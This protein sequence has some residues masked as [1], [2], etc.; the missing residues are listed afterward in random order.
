MAE[1]KNS[2]TPGADKYK[3]VPKNIADEL[4]AYESQY[5][6]EDLPIPFCGTLKLYPAT[7]HDYEVFSYCSQCL[8]LNKNQDPQG[9][10]MSQLEYLYSKTQLPGD[11]GAA[12]SYK[13]QKLFEIIFHIKNGIKC[14]KCGRVIEYNSEEFRNYITKVQEAQQNEQSIPQLV[15]S[16]EECGGNEF[17]EMM[18]FIEDPQTKK[19]VLCIN[20][21]I[22]SKEDYDRLRYLVLFQ[23]FPDYRDDSWVDPTLKQDYEEKMRLE[24]QNNDVHATLEKKIVCLSISTGFDF[25]KIY[26]MTIRKFTMA[27]TTVDDLINYK[28]MKTAAMSGFIQWP[29]DK[30]IEHWIY[31]PDKDMYGDNSYKSLSDAT[32]GLSS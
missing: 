26:N 21:Q 14:T 17:I 16:K 4:I 23:N 28:I 27:L 13:I 15:C 8:T 2:A 1:G 3:G 30:P 11:E 6:K 9:I 19:H 24:R 7:V 20:G 31:K 32:K 22:V 18:K 10:R 12:W 5:F 25:E 29:K